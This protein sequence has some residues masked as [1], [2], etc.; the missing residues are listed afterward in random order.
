MIIMV[1]LM[2]MEWFLLASVR[3]WGFHNAFIIINIESGND[4]MGMKSLWEWCLRKWEHHNDYSQYRNGNEYCVME[5]IWIWG[6]HFLFQNHFS[7]PANHFG[8]DEP[9]ISFQ[10]PQT[11][12]IACI[13]PFAFSRWKWKCTINNHVIATMDMKRWWPD[14]FHF[15]NENGVSGNDHHSSP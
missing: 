9:M 3:K 6:I 7:L 11:W 1:L 15:Q 5:V 2:E 10:L 14:S 4:V 12:R 8:A 13:R